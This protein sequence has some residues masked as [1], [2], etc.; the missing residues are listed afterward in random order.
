MFEADIAFNR[1]GKKQ[2]YII[3]DNNGAFK[4]FNV[5]SRTN[6]NSEEKAFFVAVVESYDYS[7]KER[8]V[9]QNSFNHD[10]IELDVN[11]AEQ[12]FE[13]YVEFMGLDIEQF[14]NETAKK[15]KMRRMFKKYSDSKNSQ[16][17]KTAT[18]KRRSNRQ[19]N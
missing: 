13:K 5:D 3:P 11:S 10:L 14:A 7:T 2:L 15:D 9:K 4:I 18:I 16:I 17:T 19:I 6:D 12:L 8:I 1:Q